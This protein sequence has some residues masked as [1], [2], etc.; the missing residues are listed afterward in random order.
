MSELEKIMFFL[1]KNKC[2][3]NIL[4]A[5]NGAHICD[6]CIEQAHNIVQEDVIS[7]QTISDDFK[8]LKPRSIKIIWMILSLDKMIKSSKIIFY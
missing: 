8:L 5:G 1:Q 3:Y 2:R 4:I 6:A 7:K